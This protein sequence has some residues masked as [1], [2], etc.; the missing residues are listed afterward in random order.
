MG[1]GT[2]VRRLVALTV[3]WLLA[4]AALTYAA[5]RRITSGPVLPPVTAT[6]PASTSDTALTVKVVPDVRRQAYVFAEG[7]LGDAGFG[8][9]VVGSAQGFASNTVVSQTP[10][11]GTRV[12]DTGNP[13]VVLHLAKTSGARESGEPQSVSTTKPTALKLADVVHAQ[14]ASAVTPAAKPVKKPI[15]KKTV[16]KKPVVKKTLAKKPVARKAPARKSPL[17]RPPA[18]TVP[19]ARR[20]PLDEM[21]LTTRAQALLRFFARH[22]K[23]TDANVR[24]WLYQHSWIVAG[25][26][27]GWWHG[28]EALHLLLQADDRAWQEWGIGARSAQTARGALAFAEQHAK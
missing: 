5:A 1:M 15:V 20:E 8:W 13:L 19:G 25:A 21:P 10:A 16:A 11:A 23:P 24:Y 17:Q 28:A 2:F 7:T 6:T 4:T 9:R 3:I 27:M 12:V 26:R 14:T 22:P 18:F